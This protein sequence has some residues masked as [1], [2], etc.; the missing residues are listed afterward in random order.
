MGAQRTGIRS[1]WRR[2]EALVLR[3]L[4]VV[5]A[6]SSGIVWARGKTPTSG[7]VARGEALF[8]RTWEPDD[9]RA[10]GGDGLGP[11]FNDRSCVACH[12][13]GGPGGAGPADK[14]VDIV[15]VFFNPPD[16]QTPARS[17][18]WGRKK[19]ETR[20]PSQSDLEGWWR[21]TRGSRRAGA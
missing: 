4:L 16:R 20:M 21:S 14:N 2:L 5:G 9:R 13:E 15:S 19:E 3:A 18:W 1:R 17:G 11:V 6:L 8:L 12:N 7:P 10:H